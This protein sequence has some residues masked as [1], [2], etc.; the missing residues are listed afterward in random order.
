MVKR[1][2][3]TCKYFEDKGLA[4][5]GWCRHPDRCDIQDMVLVRKAELACRN[6]WDQDLWEPSG[7]VASSEV[8]GFQHP[9]IP[10]PTATISR[11]MVARRVPLVGVHESSAASTLDNAY[12]DKLTSIGLKLS[13]RSLPASHDEVS[14]HSEN[15]IADAMQPGLSA[16][17][18]RHAVRE[19]RRRKEI[20]RK[21]E[22][23]QTKESIVRE[24]GD[25]LD[26]SSP[27]ASSPPRAAKP[28]RLAAGS[29]SGPSLP[30]SRT[31]LPIAGHRVSH[32]QPPGNT[33]PRSVSFPATPP[34]FDRKPQRQ[35]VEPEPRAIGVQ[36]EPSVDLP[37]VMEAP[38]RSRKNQTEPFPVVEREEKKS[39][40]PPRQSANRSTATAAPQPEVGDRAG[41]QRLTTAPPIPRLSERQITPGLETQ[42]SLSHASAVST[43]PLALGRDPI[44]TSTSLNA[45]PRRCETCRDFVRQGEGEKGWCSNVRAFGERRV[46]R[47]TELACRS[48]IGVWWLP[49]DDLWLSR[50]DTTHHGRPTPILDEELRTGSMGR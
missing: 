16:E 5:S 46:V 7:A 40:P 8:D 4:S 29:G 27:P 44:D 48:S 21:A 37:A 25:L 23:R 47:A 26:D 15:D 34:T 28:E 38:P 14:K 3:G 35:S 49:H 17:E 31:G 6:S 12:T 1:K 39:S 19:A 43:H 10:D 33:P 36:S 30:A 11:P 41:H 24:A 18:S 2:C 20:A 45:V 42:T 13:P 50:A 9:D 22:V 32:H